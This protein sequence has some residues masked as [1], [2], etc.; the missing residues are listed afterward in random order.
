VKTLRTKRALAIPTIVL[1]PSRRV[2]RRWILSLHE[3]GDHPWAYAPER[4]E[5]LVAWA[6]AEATP[7][8]LEGL[9]A[10]GASSRRPR[11]HLTFDDG[12]AGV[13]DRALPRCPSDVPLTVFLPTTLLAEEDAVPRGDHGLYAGLPLLGWRRVRA[14]ARDPRVTFGSHGATHRAL[15]DLSA[16]E[17]ADELDGSR[18]ALEH[19][20]GRPARFLAYPFGRCDAA[21]AHAAGRAGF[22]AGVTTIHGGVAVRPDAFRLPRVDVRADYEVKDLRRIVRGEWDFLAVAQALR[23]RRARKR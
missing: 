1:R 18:R 9:L 16:R 23:G 21:T 19:A 8:S 22:S 7:V 6:R 2:P 14:L 13:A 4:F 17:R 10:G 5:D 12:Y 20:T 15:P 11:V 3:V